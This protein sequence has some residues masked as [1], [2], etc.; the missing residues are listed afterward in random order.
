MAGRRLTL[1]ICFANCPPS[2][3]RNQKDWRMANK[4]DNDNEPIVI[5]LSGCNLHSLLQGFFD[6]FPEERDHLLTL[7]PDIGNQ[8]NQSDD[9]REE[10]D[11]PPGY[12][13][14]GRRDARHLAD[15]LE[16]MADGQH[17]RPDIVAAA[18]EIRQQ[19]EQAPEQDTDRITIYGSRLGWAEAAPDSGKPHGVIVTTPSENLGHQRRFQESLLGT[20][21]QGEAICQ[22]DVDESMLRSTVEGV[23]RGAKAQFNARINDGR[24]TLESV[25]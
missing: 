13:R 7:I 5:E 9:Y 25:T 2:E 4:S 11:H 10:D 14:I 24:L 6:V 15:L 20:T 18:A 1:G 19:V 17:G 23:P 21:P 12:L 8:F 22:L 16:R 3:Y